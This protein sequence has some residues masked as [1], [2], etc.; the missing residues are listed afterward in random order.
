ME[1][2]ITLIGK[3]ILLGFIHWMLVPFAL[4][5]LIEKSTFLAERRHVGSSHNLPYLRGLVDLSRN[6][7]HFYC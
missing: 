4:K 3:I 6:P 1:A 2:D 5:A 7:S